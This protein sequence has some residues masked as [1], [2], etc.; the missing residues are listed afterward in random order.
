[1]RWKLHEANKK[2]LIEGHDILSVSKKTWGVRI[3]GNKRFFPVQ[4]WS[5]VKQ[6]NLFAKRHTNFAHY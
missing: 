2:I 4:A 3:I 1:M 5:Q 6:H